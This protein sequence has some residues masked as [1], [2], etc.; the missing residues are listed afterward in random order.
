MNTMNMQPAFLPLHR[1]ALVLTQY[2]NITNTPD[3]TERSEV[4]IHFNAVRLILF[5]A[6]FQI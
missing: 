6:K 1:F 4:N 3:H 2:V 5:H